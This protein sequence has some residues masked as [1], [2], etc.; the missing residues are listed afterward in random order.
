MSLRTNKYIIGALF[1]GALMGMASCSD[2]FLQKDSLTSVSKTTFWKTSDDAKEGLAACYDALQNGFL[3]NDASDQNKWNGCGPLNMDAMT[4]NGGRFNW[5][6]W[7]PGYDICNGTQ[8]SSSRLIETYWAANYEAIKRCNSLVSNIDNVDMDESTREQYKA[9]AIVIRALMYLNL[10]MT[11]QDV[12]YITSTQSLTEANCEKTERATIVSNIL[13]DVQDAA[14]ILPKETTERGRITKGAALSLLGRIALYNEKW[15]VAIKAYQEVMSMGYSLFTDYTT[16]FTEENESC[17]EIIWGVRYEGPGKSEGNAMGGHWGAPLEALNGTID[18]AD[19]YYQLD[20]TPYTKKDD[21]CDIVDGSP[22]LWSATGTRYENRDPRLKT[23]LFLPGM[24]WGE[25][26]WNYG[27]SAA[28]FSTVYVMKYF[29]PDLTWSTS[30]DSG[31]DFYLIRYAEVLLSLAESYIESNQ[32]LA[33]AVKLI[34]EV[35]QRAGMPTI[36]SVEGTG[37]SQET[38]REIVR[39]ERRVELA[40]EGLRLFDLY[41]WHTLKDAV[42]RINNEAS[43]YKFAYEYRNYKGEQEYV[44]PIPQTELDSNPLLTQN[45]L[46]K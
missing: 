40:F 14:N 46:W 42:D 21:V 13:K 41:R 12:P 37:L 39:H 24:T 45:D 4:D 18:L 8:S 36:E 5:S 38:L 34:D 11:Y 6:G 19:A 15:D 27:G 16:L 31:Q 9:E 20:G 44:W 17:S 1:C 29:N 2:D 28:S 3:Y 35:R 23:T 43:T 32:N 25:A 7:M 30:W 26:N 22:D 33:D 10:T